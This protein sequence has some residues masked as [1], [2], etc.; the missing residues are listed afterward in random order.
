MRPRNEFRVFTIIFFGT[1]IHAYIWIFANGC[2]CVRTCFFV[3]CACI[4]TCVSI[5]SYETN[6]EYIY[7]FVHIHIRICTYT[8]TYTY[9][10]SCVK[11]MSNM[12]YVRQVPLKIWVVLKAPTLMSFRAR[13]RRLKVTLEIPVDMLQVVKRTLSC[14]WICVLVRLIAVFAI[15]EARMKFCNKNRHFLSYFGST[16]SKLSLR[17]SLP[18]RLSLFM[19]YRGHPGT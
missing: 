16:A 5:C 18:P 8:Y 2:G 17:T 6:T 9:T 11:Y 7:T 15:D 13:V 1:H 14:V 10:Y 19:S 12:F 3:I 4:C